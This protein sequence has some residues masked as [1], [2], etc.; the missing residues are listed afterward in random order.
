[1]HPFNPLG[2]RPGGNRGI[3]WF[4]RQYDPLR[5]YAERLAFLGGT[6][7]VNIN[8][9]PQNMRKYKIGDIVQYGD[10]LVTVVAFQNGHEAG[11][12]TQRNSNDYHRGDAD[13]VDEN[14]NEIDFSN[15]PPNKYWVNEYDLGE[16]ASSKEPPK[17]IFDTSSFEKL[18]LPQKEKDEIIAV[19]KQQQ[20]QSKLFTEW[21][22]AET[23]EYGKG[24]TF[25]FYGTPGT[26]KTWGAN[27]IAKTLGKKLHV[28]SAAE[29]QSSEP[30]AANR[31]LQE[32][33]KKAKD[34]VLLLDE[35][36]SL[37]TSRN[38]VGMVLASEINTLLTE[39]EKTEGVVVLTTNRAD[40]LDEALERR[41]S[42]IIEFPFPNQEM[43]KQIWEKLLPEKMPRG[44]YATVEKLSEY[45]LSGGQIKN[46]ILQAARLA[47]ADEKNKVE[48]S[49]FESA[50]ERVQVSKSLMG[51]DS[52]YRQKL[53][54]DIEKVVGKKKE[55]VIEEETDITK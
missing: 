11:Y 10:E 31:N 37:I 36:D 15:E 18:I 21:G 23:I 54:R 46:V 30:G 12:L 32:A 34:G 43:R 47:V 4:S 17:P 55:R 5:V 24:M 33:F 29:I 35:C 41:I 50:I 25:L 27:C 19:M 8:N 44:K 14:G 28:I 2:Y 13:A 38:D 51:K 6:G 22:L 7:G 16:V 9:N 48:L 45:N 20:N 42:L 39:I 52:R 49:H 40:T 26:G 53:V 3:G 1:M